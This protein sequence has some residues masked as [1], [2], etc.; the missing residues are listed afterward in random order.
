VRELQSLR[1]DHAPAV[2][3][4]EIANREY[5]SASISDRGE[6][7]F[8]QFDARFGQLLAAQAAGEG[9]F[10][11]LVDDTGSVLGRFNLELLGD[12]VAVLGYRVAQRVAGRGVATEA[13]LELCALAVSRHGVRRVRA[14][15]SDQNTASRRVLLKAGF[16]PV[17]PADPA[18]IGGRPGMWFERDLDAGSGEGTQ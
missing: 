17:G 16:V 11:V 7:Y 18:Q 14:A 8:E 12:G 9:A 5:F 3:E 4:F 13:V 1:A 2:L 15:T 6:E 10:H